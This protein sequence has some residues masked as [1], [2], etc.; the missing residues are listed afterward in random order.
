MIS[1]RLAVPAY[2]PL[3]WQGVSPISSPRR[4]HLE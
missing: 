4:R 3:P 1:L 2:S